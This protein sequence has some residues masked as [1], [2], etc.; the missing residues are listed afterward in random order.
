[1]RVTSIIL[2]L[3]SK[4]LISFFTSKLNVTFLV[5]LGSMGPIVNLPSFKNIASGFSLLII[6]KTSRAFPTPTFF[7]CTSRSI[8]S[9]TSIMPFPLPL[10]VP[11]PLSI[12]V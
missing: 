5:S 7:T 12:I 11:H 10:E 1:L 4:G 3:N 8:D 6:L 9:L 2:I